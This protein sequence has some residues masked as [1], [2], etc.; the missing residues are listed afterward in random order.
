MGPAVVVGLFTAYV[1]DWSI[2]A[3]RRWN[4][5]YVRKLASRLDQGDVQA[6]NKAQAAGI[7]RDALRALLLTSLGLLLAEATRHY[8]GT[9]LYHCKGCGVC[10]AECPCGAI[11]MVA[12]EI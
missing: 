12:E 11:K 6:V 4:T 2:V 5:T 3:V 7:A 10:A 9:D 1:G 8:D